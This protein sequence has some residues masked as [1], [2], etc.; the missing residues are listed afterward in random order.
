VRELKG[1]LFVTQLAPFEFAADH[2]ALG[3]DAYLSE[4]RDLVEAN[5]GY[6]PLAERLQII[7]RPD[8]SERSTA[9]V[10]DALAEAGKAFGSSGKSNASPALLNLC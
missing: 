7:C 5:G 2:S 10:R 9:E 3:L 8:A 4:V 6:L 1:V